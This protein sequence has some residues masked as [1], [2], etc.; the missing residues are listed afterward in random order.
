IGTIRELL[1]GFKAGAFAK[2]AIP[3]ILAS[4]LENGHTVQRAIEAQGVESLDLKEV[5]ELVDRVVKEREKFIRDRGESAL[6]PLMGIVMK[7]LRGRVDGQV[8]SEI[9]R[10]KISQLLK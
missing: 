6:G 7:E 1:D 8:I 5:R 10:E 3:K 9:L 2:E 4:V